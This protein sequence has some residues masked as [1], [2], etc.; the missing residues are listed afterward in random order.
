MMYFGCRT[1]VVNIWV[2]T[3]V[4][5]EIQFVFDMFHDGTGSDRVRLPCDAREKALP[6]LSCAGARVELA[7]TALIECLGCSRK[8]A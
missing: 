3:F 1:A 4:I 2:E 5:A 8:S 7:T 6:L